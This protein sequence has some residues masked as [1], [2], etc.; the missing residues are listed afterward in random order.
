MGSASRGSA[1][2]ASMATTRS[3]PPGPTCWPVSAATPRRPPPTRRPGPW[4]PTPSNAVSSPTGRRWRPLPRV[5]AV[6]VPVARHRRQ[7]AI[8]RRRDHRK[9]ADDPLPAL[10]VAVKEVDGHLAPA[11][12][13]VAGGGELRVGRIPERPLPEA[14]LADRD[15]DVPGEPVELL[16]RR[17]SVAAEEGLAVEPPAVED[18]EAAP[19]VAQRDHEVDGLLGHVAGRLPTGHPDPPVVGEADLLLRVLRTGRHQ[20]RPD[21]GQE[22]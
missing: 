13:G 12:D 11:G 4:P 5:G 1:S 15:V 9:A 17:M 2:T 3:T 6:E 18:A 16:Q 7:P 22:R 10:V 20:P 14:H 8:L 19:D 21:P